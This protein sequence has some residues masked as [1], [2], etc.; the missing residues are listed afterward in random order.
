MKL[1]F[2]DT[3]EFNY[4]SLIEY[5]LN[6]SWSSVHYT[7]MKILIDKSFFAGTTYHVLKIVSCK[8]NNKVGGI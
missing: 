6:F 7:A 1:Y 4:S 5:I 8:W 3:L 2:K